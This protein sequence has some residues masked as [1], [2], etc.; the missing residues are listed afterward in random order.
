MVDFFPKG[1]HSERSLAQGAAH[2]LG[3]TA[4]VPGQIQQSVKTVV[5]TPILKWVTIAGTTNPRPFTVSS[6][7]IR[8]DN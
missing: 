3:M 8:Q 1:C 4:R 5:L 6:L 7:M 2:L